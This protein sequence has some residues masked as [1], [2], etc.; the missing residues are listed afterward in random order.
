[1]GTGPE[2]I[3]NWDTPR[4]PDDTRRRDM[5]EYGLQS[6]H[7]MLEQPLRRIAHLMAISVSEEIGLVGVDKILPLGAAEATV[8]SRAPTVWNVARARDQ[9]VVGRSANLPVG[10]S[11]RPALQSEST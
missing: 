3:V 2:H 6:A 8:Q 10:S 5:L 4:V 1:M 9:P 7:I 11:G